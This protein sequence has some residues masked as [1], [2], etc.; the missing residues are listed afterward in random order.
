MRWF[1]V[2]LFFAVLILGIYGVSMYFTKESNTFTIEN[3]VP[4]PI[5]KVFSQFNNFQN[6]TRWN[7]YFAGSPSMHVD[8]FA[9][10]IGQ[11]ASISFLDEKEDRKGEMYLRYENPLKTLRFQLFE[12]NESMPSLID[13]KFTPSGEN[14]TKIKWIIHTPKKTF[15]SRSANFWTESEF[16]D[17]LEKSFLRLDTIMGNKVHQEIMLGNLK[18][19][20]VMVQNEEGMLLLGVNVS[21]SSNANQL[22]PSVILNHHKV[23]NY[24]KVDLNKREDEFG[25]PVLLT[26]A[27]AGSQKEISYF[28]GVPLSKRVSVADNNFSF[29]TLSE[30]RK[31]VIYFRGDFKDRE[32]AIKKLVEKAKKDSLRYG[33]LQQTFLEAPRENGESN[34]KFALPVFK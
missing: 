31:Y 34:L 23:I 3:E 19:D 22:L 12:G 25:L 16:K 17:N 10:Y 33:D 5:D 24:A 26:D 13:L 4:Y 11:G 6:L 29:R 20:S 15:F 9:P 21:S 27:E 18:Y 28:Y 14:R 7:L 8:Y 30:A 1:R 32:N 2:L